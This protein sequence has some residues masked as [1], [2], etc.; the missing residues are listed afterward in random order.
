[1]KKREGG[2]KQMLKP[3]VLTGRAR[4]ISESWSWTRPWRTA[5][6]GC[7]M[8]ATCGEGWAPGA[9]PGAALPFVTL[10][11]EFLQT[12]QEETAT[13]SWLFASEHGHFAPDVLSEHPNH[14]SP[15]QRLLVSGSVSCSF[16][17]P[18]GGLFMIFQKENHILKCVHIRTLVSQKWCSFAR[19][20]GRVT[21]RNAPLW[22]R[23]WAGNS[24]ICGLCS[25][26][27][28]CYVDDRINSTFHQETIVQRSKVTWPKS[29]S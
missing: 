26:T 24:H 15:L 1:M 12:F 11:R 16:L 27:L 2:A 3:E 13:Q 22:V 19:G 7:R 17:N 14:L 20:K 5:A 10:H 4:E 9:L 18:A 8:E 28:P 6:G 25:C 23:L 21:E 29:H